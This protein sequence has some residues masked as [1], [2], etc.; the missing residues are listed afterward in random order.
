MTLRDSFAAELRGDGLEIGA[1][2]NPF[3]LPPSARALTVDRFDRARLAQ[4]YTDVEIGTIV[5]PDVVA[6]AHTLKGLDDGSFDFVVASHVIEHLHN[7]I[8]AVEA[9]LRVLRP[10]GRL[11]LV[12]PDCRYTFD[13]GRPLTPFTHLVWDYESEG[14]ELKTLS[15]LFHIAE[16]NLNM[17]DHL[18]P[19]SAVELAW[20]ILGDSYDTHFHVWTHRSFHEHLERLVAERGMPLRILKSAC[21][22]TI[23]S[24]FLLEL[25][26]APLSG[27]TR[28]RRR[29]AVPTARA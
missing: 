23:E 25:V 12:V 21:D 29:L 24:L 14:T 20:K 19:S 15:D 5:A 7:P 28:L 11:L 18:T 22:G 16:C 27:L 9:W 10:G 4:I 26:G 3:P 13:K 2:H 8:R 1:L 6:D 17:H